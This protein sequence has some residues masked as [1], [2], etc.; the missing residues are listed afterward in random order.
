MFEGHHCGHYGM[1]NGD[2]YT[3]YFELIRGK[4]FFYVSQQDN[5]NMA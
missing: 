3:M 5:L 1:R 4:H 2:L